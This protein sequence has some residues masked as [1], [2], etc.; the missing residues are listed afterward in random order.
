MSS[1][2]E[3]YTGKL[4]AVIT[5][6]GRLILGTLKGFDQTINLIL[7]NSRERVF[8]TFAGAKEV[9]LGL[10]IIRGDNV[11]LLG[12]VDEDLDKSVDYQSMM[13]EPINQ[14]KT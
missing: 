10:Y 11:V 3:S 13:A 7:I 9:S 5:G 14:M 12:E 1:T 6:D 2:L 8:S 4:V